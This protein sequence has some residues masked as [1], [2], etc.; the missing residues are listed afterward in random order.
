MLITLGLIISKFDIEFVE[1][2]NL[3]GSPSDRPGVDDERFA[4]GGAMPPDR[5]MKVRW[6]RIW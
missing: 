3:D 5:D 2:T 1:W 4:G 6:R